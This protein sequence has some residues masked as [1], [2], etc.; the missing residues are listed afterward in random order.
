MSNL[1][2]MVTFRVPIEIAAKLKKYALE[3][4][5]DVSSIVREAVATYITK[6]LTED[7]IKHLIRHS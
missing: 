6:Y 7:D 2:V 1:D 5:R 4:G 3:N